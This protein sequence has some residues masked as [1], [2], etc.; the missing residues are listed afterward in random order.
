M[1]TDSE[2]GLSSNATVKLKHAYTFIFHMTPLYKDRNY[3]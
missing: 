3:K 2:K 1:F